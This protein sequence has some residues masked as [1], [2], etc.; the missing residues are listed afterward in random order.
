M[1]WTTY[2]H[3]LN[4]TIDLAGIEHAVTVD[5][6]MLTDEGKTLLEFKPRKV[7]VVCDRLKKA[8]ELV[9]RFVDALEPHIIRVS[10][11]NREVEIGGHKYIFVNQDRIRM[12]VQ[13]RRGLEIIGGREFERALDIHEERRNGRT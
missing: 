10:Y 11:R 8:D 5:N 12:I 3:I 13:G 6:S 1:D 2:G 4:D 7:Y 9:K